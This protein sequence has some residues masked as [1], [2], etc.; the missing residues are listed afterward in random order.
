MESGITALLTGI[1]SGISLPIILNTLIGVVGYY[2]VKSIRERVNRFFAY[3][4]VRM[5]SLGFQSHVFWGD[6]LFMVDDI[7]EKFGSITLSN[8]VH[9]LFIP[10]DVWMSTPKKI[11]LN[12][13]YI[14]Q[15]TV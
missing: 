12:G 2:L 1:T 5:R 11:P 15:P 9:R 7:S 14:K 10:L 6:E 4:Q 3:R 8:K 13:S